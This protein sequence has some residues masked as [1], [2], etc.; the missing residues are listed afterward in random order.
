[1]RVQVV[2]L[3]VQVVPAFILFC[4]G[5]GGVHQVQVVQGAGA[6]GVLSWCVPSLL[7]ALSLYA[8]R[9]ACKYGSI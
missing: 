9:V 3:V 7:S 4:G 8:C 1:M 2:G 6:F 5:G